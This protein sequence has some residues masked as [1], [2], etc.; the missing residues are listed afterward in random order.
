MAKPY[1]LTFLAAWTLVLPAMAQDPQLSQFY[2][3][4]LY[5][6]PALTGNTHQDRIGLNYR[7]QWPAIG[8]GYRTYAASYDHHSPGLH[9][10][11]GGMVMH[12]RSG[13]QGLSFTQMALSY[14]YE[15]R[16]SRKRAIRGGLR[17]AYTSRS[18]DQRG[19]LF[20]DQVIR[21]NAAA[22]IEPTTFVNASY[23][24]FSAGLLYYSEQFWAGI[25]ANHLNEPQQSLYLEGDAEL[26]MRTS[27]HAGYR[28]PVDGRP[29]RHSNTTMTLAAHY[30][31]Q[32]Q[33][34]QMDLGGY[35]E[36]DHLTFGM[37]YRG[38]PGVKA[39]EPGQPNDD[40][41]ILMLG[42]E[43]AYQLQLVYSYDVTV[44]KLTL[45]SGGAHEVSLI[46]EW[47]RSGKNR[48]YRSVPCPKF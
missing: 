2:A 17:A 7:L 34:D 11:I 43:T 22:S 24:D 20:A 3:A 32:G 14:A 18:I 41:V 5:L 8:P 10:G 21:D 31:A 30:K 42:Y 13:S 26:P 1:L 23:F 45:K 39:Y 19:M 27:V 29:F 16:L 40:A 15:A 4:P 38:L 25:S 36:H 28:F 48:K 44:S 12:D 35:V 37:W 33:W 46:Y 9:S 6:N 47:P